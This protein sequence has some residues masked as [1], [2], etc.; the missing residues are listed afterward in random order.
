MENG[1][2]DSLGGDHMLGWI[3]QALGSDRGS[4]DRQKERRSDAGLQNVYNKPHERN[5]VR[6]LNRPSK[7]HHSH[8]S[9][10]KITE[11]LKRINQIMSKI[12]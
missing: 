9:D 10:I 12:I 3:N 6:D 2:K 7:S 8:N 11:A 4:L 5:N 1:E